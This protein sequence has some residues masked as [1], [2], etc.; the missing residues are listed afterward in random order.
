MKR[1][2]SLAVA[3]VMLLALV[4]LPAWAAPAP[5]DKQIARFNNGA[6]P[7]T[8]DPA[9]STGIP[10]ANIEINVFEGLTRIGKG[11][12]PVPGVAYKWEISKDGKV[13][14]FHLRKSKWSNGDPVTAH[15]FVYAW[16]RALRPET[17]S[18]YAYQL[19]YIKNAQAFNEGKIKDASQL[20]VKALDDFT[21][22][23]TLEAPTPYFLFLCGFPT[24]MPVHKKFVEA[25]PKGWFTKPE[26]YIGN[27]PFKMAKWEHNSKIEL[28]KNPLY[29]DAKKVKLE[30]VV[31]S[32]IDSLTTEE[33]MFETN[34][35][36]ILDNIP[37]PSMDRWKKD[38]GFKMDPMIGTYYY[39]VN[40]EKIKDKRVR[41]ALF[42][43]IDRETL[44]DKVRKND[45][46]IPAYAWA[47]PGFP[48]PTAKKKGD[49]FRKVGG[50]F[51]TTGDFKKDVEK[52]KKLLAEAGYADGKGLSVEILFNTNELHKKIAEFVQQQWKTNLGI[53]AK[54]SNQEWKV[55]LDTRDTGNFQVA[56]A[57]WIGDYVH[58]MTFMDMMV[59]GGGNNDSF[60]GNKKYD[61]LIEKAKSSVDVKVGFQ[62]MHEAEKILMDEMPI[63][64]LTFYGNPNVYKPWIKGVNY[65]AL[66]FVDFKNAWIEKH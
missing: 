53:D 14:T 44:V 1:W 52:A 41:Q 51:I 59:S 45:G 23:V 22:Q 17:A 55:Y 42:L 11:D 37:L 19:Y 34:Q 36:D 54:L 31:I 65:S 2:L 35:L 38:P 21:L 6:E 28:V 60:W 39:I 50:D 48:D 32:L 3:M 9:M 33:A 18:E 24:L 30:K 66:G 40:C 15:D 26:T 49:D 25:D 16:T 13:Y 47:P 61:E 10:E 46:H 5:K 57:G 20:G 64:P 58:P 63:I 43:G 29:W 4:A 27:G 8:I 12:V 56:R 7:E 62:A